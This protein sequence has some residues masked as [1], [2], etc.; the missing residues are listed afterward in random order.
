[1]T[2][3]RV[4]PAPQTQINMGNRKEQKKSS[5]ESTED[6]L[7]TI[8][9]HAPPPPRRNSARRNEPAVVDNNNQISQRNTPLS[10]QMLEG[11][12]LC[13]QSK[14]STAHPTPMS[15]PKAKSALE[16]QT[17]HRPTTLTT[18]QPPTIPDTSSS[19]LSK[20]KSFIGIFSRRD[21]TAKVA[22]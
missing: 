1:L 13:Q 2:E 4:P 18:L 22:S 19:K 15:I 12:Q 14:T 5:S 9:R 8:N 17:N 3:A 11:Q 10:P 16:E 7:Y 6:H 21:N 20:R